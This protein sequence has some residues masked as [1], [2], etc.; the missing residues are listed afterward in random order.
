MLMD[1]F[2]GYSDIIL[3]FGILSDTFRDVV[4]Y[5]GCLVTYLGIF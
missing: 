4:I 1:I 2:L 5:L 3:T